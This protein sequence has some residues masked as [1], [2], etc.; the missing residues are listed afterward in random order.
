MSTSDAKASL[1]PVRNLSVTHFVPAAL[2]RRQHEIALGVILL[3]ALFVRVYGN[4]LG[5][6]YVINPDEP[7]VVD[8]ALAMLRTGDYNPHSFIYP[9]LYTYLQFL[10]YVAHFLWGVSQGVY[11][12]LAD[13]PTS[14]H[15][16][17]WATGFYIWGRCLTAVLGAATVFLVYRMGARLYGQGAGLAGALFLAFSLLHSE[18]S[19]YITVDV[20]AAFFSALAFVFIVELFVRGRSERRENLR[21]IYLLGGLSV[22]LA[23][24]TKYNAVVIIVPFLLAHLL[25]APRRDWLSGNL[26]AGLALIAVGFLASSPFAVAGLP[27]FL[28]DVAS[29]IYHY[30]FAGHLGYEGSNNWLY[31]MNY[32]WSAETAASLMGAGGILLCFFRR[33]RRDILVLLFPLLYFAGLSQY[34]VNFLRNLLP[35]IPFLSLLGGIFL[36]EV[37]GWFSRRVSRPV[38]SGAFAPAAL[39]A[40]LVVLPGLTILDGDHYNS[41]DDSRALAER[42]IRTNLPQ[43]ARI[44]AEL[45]AVQWR[46]STTVSTTNSLISHSYQ[47]YLQQGFQYLVANSVNYN[48]YLHDPK[49]F[50]AESKAYD[51]IFQ[52]SQAV[53]EFPGKP[54]PKVTILKVNLSEDVVDI[55]FRSGASFGGAIGLIGYDFGKESNPDQPGSK[56]MFKAGEA[57]NLV[58]YWKAERSIPKDYTVFV[59]LLDASGEIVTQRDTQPL[60]GTSRTSQWKPGDFVVDSAPLALPV[61]AA[62][63][64]YRLEIGLYDQKTM[65]RLRVTAK[66][67]KAD[68][69]VILGPIEVR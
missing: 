23:V 39:A 34:K 40:T 5:L 49:K 68:D 57:V 26:F 41:Q 33:S 65:E 51:K 69:K 24:G 38:L 25:S 32:F 35:V 18:H 58:L 64:E 27:Q 13:L 19:H 29:I 43:N 46:D 48:Q 28:D 30:K 12:N 17:T 20:P 6:P 61:D 44:M 56:L 36:A 54:G 31:Y 9:T 22:G 60:N 14:T 21:W 59:H 2:L 11:R 50:P 16:A 7:A 37:V 53:K 52:K 62:P 8:R 66:D 3:L 15:I 4:E 47:W 67:G 55:P 45:S 42:W 10:V 63:G 1:R